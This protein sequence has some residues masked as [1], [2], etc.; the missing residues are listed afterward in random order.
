LEK[1]DIDGVQVDAFVDEEKK[2]AIAYEA[3]KDVWIGEKDIRKHHSDVDQRLLQKRIK[4]ALGSK[5]YGDQ[6]KL[7]DQAIQ[8]YIDSKRSPEDFEKFKDELTPA[9]RG[10]Y[11]MSQKLSPEIKEIADEI[12]DMY[13]EMGLESQEAGIINNTLENYAG[14]IWDLEKKKGRVTTEAMRKF[15]T[16]TGHAKQRTFATILEGWAAGYELKVKG[17]TTNL[18]I[19]RD[20]MVKTIE[21]KRFLDSLQKIKTIDGEPLLTINPPEGEK[22][23]RVEHPNFKVWKHAGKAEKGKSYGKNF[24]MDEDG[25]LFEKRELYAPA[26]QGKNLNNMLGLSKLIDLPGFN[27]STKYN[28]IFKAWILQ[29]NL[30]HHLAYMRSYE[31][32]TLGKRFGELN[33]VDAYKQGIELMEQKNPIIAQLVRNGL[34]LGLK[35]DWNEDLLRE[36]TLIGKILDK[37][38]ATKAAKDKILQLREAQAEFLFGEFGAGLKAKAAMIEYRNL[39][40]KHPNMDTNTVAKMA[41]DL[42]NDDFGGLHLQRMGRNPTLQHFFRLFALAPD[43]TESNIRSMVKMVGAGTKE[44]RNMYRRFWAGIATKGVLLTVAA[45][46]LFSIGAEDDDDKFFGKLKRTWGTGDDWKK[47][48]W[49]DVDVTNIYKALGGKTKDRKYFSI[50]GHFKDPLKFSTSTLRSLQHKGSVLFKTFYEALAGE[51]WAQRRY[52][53]FGELIGTGSDLGMSAAEELKGQTVTWKKGKKGPLT[54]TRIP[55][56]LLSQVKGLQPVQVQNLIAWTAGEMEGFDAIA[57]S[58]GLGVRTTYGGEQSVFYKNKKL[59]EEAKD[60]IEFY[61]DKKDISKARKTMSKNM[62]LLKMDKARKEVEKEVR[63]LKKIQTVLKDRKDKEKVK[64][65]EDK[66]NE[67]LKRFNKEFNERVGK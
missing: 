41:A 20:S 13:Q 38:K 64:L 53:T 15:G 31:L 26:K 14:R 67:L 51:D 48:R 10:I 36:K 27:V 11:N 43:W 16:K 63:K 65:Y 40:K 60:K 29:S 57:N 32:G 7:T 5:R 6:A 61:K 66:I 2:A 23:V 46:A 4:K 1:R 54:P 12:S 39:I 25:N 55:S 58:L 45:N 56:Y 47:L 19:L 22:Y 30:F 37:T 35:Q 50:L 3:L 33:P 28:A 49:L 18:K 59:I 8:I 62:A 9:Q 52:T 21:D 44:E 42:I 24:F 17:A 34:T